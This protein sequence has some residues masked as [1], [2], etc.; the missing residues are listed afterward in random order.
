MVLTPVPAGRYARSLRL[1]LHRA[2]REGILPAANERVEE[3]RP[4]PDA[5]AQTAPTPEWLTGLDFSG[6]GTST[7]V[8]GVPTAPQPGP[9]TIQAPQAA[10]PGP[11]QGAQ[12]MQ[13]QQ[14]QQHQLHAP[15]DFDNLTG[16]LGLELTDV[17]SLP[18]FLNGE[19][20]TSVRP[21]DTVNFVGLEDF[22]VPPEL[23]TLLSGFRENM[24]Q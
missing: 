21:S 19:L 7:T 1:I 20:G 8:P 3:P 9:T 6:A 17:D 11:P 15:F 5:P 23:D 16:H 13:Q 18:L 24:G 22:F 4:V 10:P 14:Q 2:R 12:L